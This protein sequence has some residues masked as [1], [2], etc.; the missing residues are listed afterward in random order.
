MAANPEEVLLDPWPWETR[1]PLLCAVGWHTWLGWGRCLDRRIEGG[2]VVCHLYQ[3][4]WCRACG[5]GRDRKKTFGVW[6]LTPE[7]ALGLDFLTDAEYEYAQ[8]HDGPL[9]GFINVGA[10]MDVTDSERCGV[11]MR[12][13]SNQQNVLCRV[14]FHRYARRPEEADPIYLRDGLSTPA[15]ACCVRCRHFGHRRI[16]RSP[17]HL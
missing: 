16:T 9:L 1:K 5:A 11:D 15:D 2:V 10:R 14:G 12:L 17:A 7:R 6:R 8:L 3:W 13:Q 4:R